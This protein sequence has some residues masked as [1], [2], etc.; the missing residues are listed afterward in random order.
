MRKKVEMCGV[1]IFTQ[2]P[3]KWETVV[4]IGD[5]KLQVIN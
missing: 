5:T 1:F 2:A 4:D 3:K